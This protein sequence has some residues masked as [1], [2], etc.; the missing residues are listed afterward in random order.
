MEVVLD[1]VAILVV[2]SSRPSHP[3]PYQLVTPGSPILSPLIPFSKVMCASSCLGYKLVAALLAEVGLES[4]LESFQ[5]FGL[6]AF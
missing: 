4:F 1:T 5:V 6:R 2:V 3:Y